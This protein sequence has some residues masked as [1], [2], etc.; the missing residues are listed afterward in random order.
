MPAVV[1]ARPTGAGSSAGRARPSGTRE[2]WD[3]LPTRSGTRST[4]ARRRSA[5][6]EGPDAIE[7]HQPDPLPDGTRA[8]GV[9]LSGGGFR[10]SLAGLGT[11]RY[12][13]DA[14]LLHRVRLISSVSGGSVL[15]G[16]FAQAYAELRRH[17]FAP[18][19]FDE[20]VLKPFLATVTDSS[21]T[22]QLVR[23]LW[24]AAPPGSS[25]ATVLERC[26]DERFFGRMLL[27]ELPT[28][29]WFEFNAANVATAARFRFNRDLAGDYI[30]G[31]VS[32]SGSGLRLATAVA[33]SAAVPG[34]FSPMRL[35]AT[36]FPCGDD[37]EVVLVDGGAYD[38]LG[39]DAISK[40]PE[41]FFV[42]LNSGGLFRAP[43]LGRHFRVPVV[44][45]LRR[46][47][48]VLYRQVSAV[49]SRWLMG[50]LTDG[51]SDGVM[52]TLWT[53][54]SAEERVA[55]AEWRGVAR[56]QDPATA[57]ELAGTATSFGRF[58]P[59]LARALVYRG[60]WLT[61]AAF[62]LHQR[63]QVPELP[64]WR[65]ISDAGGSTTRGARARTEWRHDPRIRESSG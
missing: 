9:A 13:A 28:G 43:R 50:R 1:V 10:A 56:E 32:T 57:E 24:R 7:R 5:L 19:A 3:P 11:L 41:L 46:A 33:A 12:L 62:A 31:S 16:V 4:P 42:A 27:E 38:N 34:L 20:L 17:Q 63:H 6:E 51:H 48:A 26:L 29:C 22:A 30:I 55:L 14:D 61:G 40:R 52:A 15:N 37:H 60:W 64:G 25:R 49:R 35:D 36:P 59:V 23:N 44:A 18:E 21:L 54:F 58:D 53:R 39:L 65:P 8:I 45:D 47:N 2:V